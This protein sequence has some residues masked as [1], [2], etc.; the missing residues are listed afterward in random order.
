MFFCFILVYITAPNKIQS[1]DETEN[2]EGIL[3]RK[4]CIKIGHVSIT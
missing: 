4:Q 3:Y 2:N 1:E